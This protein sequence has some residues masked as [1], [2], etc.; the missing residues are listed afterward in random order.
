VDEQAGAELGALLH[1]GRQ[2]L[3][4]RGARIDER[5]VKL[6]L[7]L[8]ERIER[9]RTSLTQRSEPR[10][11]GRR[12][13]GGAW[14]V[15]GLADMRLAFPSGLE[16]STSFVSA[17]G[18]LSEGASRARRSPRPGSCKAWR[19]ARTTIDHDPAPGRPLLHRGRRHPHRRGVDRQRAAAGARRALAEPRRARP[20]EPVWRPWV[21]ELSRRH[22]YI[23][24]DQRGCGLSDRTLA[25]SSLDNFVGDLET[26]VDHSASSASR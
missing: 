17:G 18:A 20:R 22:T 14:R 5:D 10:L 6:V 11:A 12:R 19:R 24:Y 1:E 25:G 4:G 16:I 23:R 8:L 13:C 7:A 3:V 2:R 21:Q 15:G 9:P 26:V